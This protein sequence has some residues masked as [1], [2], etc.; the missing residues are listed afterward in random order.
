[1][2]IIIFAGGTGTRLWPLSRKNSPKQFGKIFNGKSTLQITVERVEKAFG[3]QNIYLSTNESYVSIVKEQLPQISASNIIAE[4][5]KRDVAPA[6][7]YNLLRLRKLGY[8]GPVVILW[9]DHVMNKPKEFIKALKIG[10]KLVQNNPKQLVF[11]GEKPRF[12]NHNLGWIHVGKKITDGQYQFLEWHY[13]PPL[14]KCLEMFTSGQWYW[15]PGYFIVDLDTIITLYQKVAPK[16][17]KKLNEIAQTI[18]TVEETETLRKIY[19]QIE[20]ISFDNAIIEKVSPEQ[21]IVILVNMEWTDPGTLYALKEYLTKNTKDN[22]VRGLGYNL[23]TEDSLIINEE[24]DKLI[25]T[26]GLKGMVVINT[27]DALVVIHK[28]NVPQIKELVEKLAK[29]KKLA[30]YI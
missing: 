15:N 8:H 1:M 12:A 2:K 9:A 16:M 18:G 17:Y 3:I 14:K 5:E 10:E 19:P 13:R 24:E 23:S 26:V 22:Y 27:K 25:S 6:V 11:L 30:Q 29:D 20:S 21:A 4:P 7:G 28:D